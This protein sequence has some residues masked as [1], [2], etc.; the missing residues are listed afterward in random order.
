M[1]WATPEAI[2]F[3]KAVLLLWLVLVRLNLQ[4]HVQFWILNTPPSTELWG[5]LEK[6]PLERCGEIEIGD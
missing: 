3:D 1:F 4:Q 2:G 5:N 6:L